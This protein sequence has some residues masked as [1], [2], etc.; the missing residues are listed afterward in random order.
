MHSNP[1]YRGRITSLLVSEVGAVAV[2]IGRGALDFYEEIL[3]QQEDQASRRFALAPK[4]SNTS[5]TSAKRN[6]WSTPPKPPC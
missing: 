1:F 3:S 4:K 5:A 6:R 2:G